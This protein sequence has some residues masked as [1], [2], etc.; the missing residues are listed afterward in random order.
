MNEASLIISVYNKAKELELI[1]LAL[2]K[3]SFSNYE[4]IV[5]EDGASPEI[6]AAVKA[7]TGTF[8]SITHIT[9]E[10]KGFRKNRILNEA[11]RRAASDYLIFT[12]GDCIPHHDFIKA[13]ISC[14]EPQTVLCG[15]RVALGENLSKK[16]L[17]GTVE[18]LEHEKNHLE[19]LIDSLKSS[20]SSSKNIEEGY[21]I[22]NKLFRKLFFERDTH[23]LGCNFST[24]KQ[25]LININGFDENY[26]GPGIGEDSDIEFRLRLTGA[27]FKS[28]RNL[29][30]QY[31][32]YHGKTKEEAK[33]LEYFN[34][35]KEKN[36]SFCENG[37]IKTADE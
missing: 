14:K 29:A 16:L 24:H 25:M 37:L 19:K 28:V 22:K 8:N 18:N 32:L 33:N 34:K 11:I 2:K 13:H 36:R 15:R 7:F 5:A 17:S 6:K 23:I 12:D 27:K 3:Q 1:F 26:E 21:I 31:H 30:V 4:I 10:D 9:Q 20:D 35:V